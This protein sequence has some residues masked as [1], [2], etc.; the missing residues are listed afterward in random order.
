MRVMYLKTLPL[1]GCDAD[2]IVTM[3]VE[4]FKSMK[5]DLAKM[6]MFTSDGAAVMLGCN[7]GVFVK[8][9]GMSVPHLIEHHCVAHKEALAAGTAYQSIAYFVE[10]ENV[11]K[12]IYSHFS[13]L[14]V[15][16]ANLKSLFGVLQQK[17]IKLKKIH[18]I[19]WLSRQEAIEAV[20]KS[21]Q[22]LVL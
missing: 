2:S 21:Y 17:Y 13:H 5:V 1:K 22:V 6:I 18:D 20:V 16:I 7:N 11:I 19:C 3:I 9:R 14:S 10:L 12:A 8:L 15:K 4:F